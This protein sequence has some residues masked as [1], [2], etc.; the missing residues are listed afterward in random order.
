MD[1]QLDVRKVNI[2]LNDQGKSKGAGFVT[3][4]SSE[5]AAKAIE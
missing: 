1:L 4:G 5:E 2:M 3:F